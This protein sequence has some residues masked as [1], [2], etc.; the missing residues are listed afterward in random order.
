[1]DRHQLAAIKR[2]LPRNA[3]VSDFKKYLLAADFVLKGEPFSI[4]SDELETA[5]LALA[6]SQRAE[7]ESSAAA[8]ARLA[9]DR[10]SD[11]AKLYA[12]MD[13]RR[14]VERHAQVLAKRS[15]SPA[16][17]ANYSK[18]GR[19]FAN[20]E[21]ALDAFVKSNTKPGESHAAATARLAREDR[22]FGELYTALDQQRRLA[23]G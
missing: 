8:F 17:A 9:H 5:M 18:A 19:A 1:M 20:A 16:D 7:G 23:V 11:V 13:V 22:R 4:S 15:T 2:R 3:T 12:A 21:A 6:E 10:D 14:V